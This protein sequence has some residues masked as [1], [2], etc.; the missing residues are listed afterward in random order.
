MKDRLERIREV[1]RKGLD[2]SWPSM[3]E[4]NSS[5]GLKEARY[6]L[7]KIQDLLNEPEDTECTC[8][9]E[10]CDPKC[11]IHE[12]Y[13]INKGQVSP[14]APHPKKNNT[15]EWKRVDC[16][17]VPGVRTRS[18]AEYQ[19]PDCEELGRQGKP[20]VCLHESDCPKHK[21]TTPSKE[22]CGDYCCP[23]EVHEPGCYFYNKPKGVDY[24]DE[25]HGKR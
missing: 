25:E 14:A 17:C 18:M 6:A 8:T 9:K 13:W 23:A 22:C 21:K 7:L 1:V 12:G 10:F 16:T 19:C 4:D 20:T 2:D 11:P 3:K 15:K 5:T 24:L